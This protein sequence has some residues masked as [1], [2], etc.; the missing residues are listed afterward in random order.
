MYTHKD[1]S[2]RFVG[3]VVSY[4]FSERCR[5]TYTIESNSDIPLVQFYD[6]GVSYKDARIIGLQLHM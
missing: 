2:G 5:W 6:F 4:M 3:Y 1:E